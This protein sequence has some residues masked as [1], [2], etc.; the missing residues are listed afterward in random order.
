MTNLTLAPV[1]PKAA[2][3]L[4]ALYA[5]ALAAAEA[6]LPTVP[7]G[8]IVLSER[9]TS[10]LVADY[11]ESYGARRITLRSEDY[12]Y[13]MTL[14]TPFLGDPEYAFLRPGRWTGTEERRDQQ[15]RR[16]DSYL[17]HAY[18]TDDF[19]DLVEVSA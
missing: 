13:E 12:R 1:S 11:R 16:W 17:R 9:P 4:H 15:G 14:R 8:A 10:G 6:S 18:V 7:A 19:G 2:E 3:L 5:D